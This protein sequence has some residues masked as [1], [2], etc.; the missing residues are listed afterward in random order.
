MISTF[1]E[2]VTVQFKEYWREPEVLFWTL[3]FPVTVAWILGVAL[4]NKPLLNY[5]V[6]VVGEASALIKE[7]T[8]DISNGFSTSK[9]MVTFANLSLDQAML[10]LKKGELSLILQKKDDKLVYLFDPANSEAEFLYLSIEKK[11]KNSGETDKNV[12]PVNSPGNRYIDYLIPGLIALGIMNST[13][14]GIGWTLIEFRIKKF[15]RRMV[16]TP[17]N[18]NVFLFSIFFT[19]TVL[20]FIEAS[21]LYG[22]VHL[23][24]NVRL[25]GSFLY[26]ILMFFSGNVAFGGLAVLIASR[27]D[28]SRVGNGIVNAVTV[29]LFLLSG[30]FFS[31]HS[32][33]PFMVNI[34]QWLPLT[35]LADGLRGIFM[36][37]IELK[38]LLFSS[39]YL[40]AT[41]LF[42]YICGIRIYKW[43]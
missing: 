10:E 38:Q 35:V 40:F 26:L 24:F 9:K 30:V 18:R 25:E 1:K 14:W 2:L 16:A 39:L 6:A 42:F 3:V 7:Q 5:R 19:R 37:V 28:N 32:F 31:Y 12:I 15:L 23:L 8:L 34:I 4:F 36:N 17:L 41:G 43:Y 20:S 29:P 13:L 33:P 22:F 27:T 21:L 11:W